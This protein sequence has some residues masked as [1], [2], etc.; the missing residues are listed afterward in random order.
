M[1]KISK[2]KILDKLNKMHKL[3]DEI[4]NL[5]VSKIW[6]TA[7]TEW[8]LKTVYIDEDFNRC[9]CGHYPIKEICVINN[10]VNNNTTIVGNCCVK[11]FLNLTS[12]KILSSVKRIKINPEKSLNLESLNY[13]LDNKCMSD[14]E[15]N[16]Y[17]NIMDIRNL[18]IKQRCK[19]VSINNNCIK[20][21]YRNLK[22]Q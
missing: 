7:K 15:Y 11:K 2:S 22:T 18:S 20:S 1:H 9:L 5:S 14:W 6:L 4:L 13:F 21:I 16:F 10:N 8:Y 12:D 3:V 19:K 17:I